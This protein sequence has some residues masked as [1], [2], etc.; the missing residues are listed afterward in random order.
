[1]NNLSKTALE[2]GVIVHDFHF[3]FDA[4]AGCVFALDLKS[5]KFVNFNFKFLVFAGG[6]FS[7]NYYTNSS[8][9][10][11]TGDCHALALKLGG[12]MEDAE[13][14]QFHPTG[15][16]GTGI[17]ISEAVRAE[18]GILL[19]SKGERFMEKYSPNFLE[20][21]PRDVIARAIFAEGGGKNP[22][23]LSLKNI[24]KEMIAKKLKGTVQTAKFFGGVDVFKEDI[25]VFPTSHYNM[26]G[27]KV[28]ENYRM[29]GNI[30][31]IGECAGG[32][33]HGANRLG[34]NSLLELFT[35]S[36]LVCKEIKQSKRDFASEVSINLDFLNRLPKITFEELLKIKLHLAKLMQEKCGVLRE[37]SKMQ[38]ALAEVSSMLSE[39]EKASPHINSLVFSNSFVLY[40]EVKNLLILSIEVLKSAIKR[41]ESRGSHTRI[42]YP[43][44]NPNLDRY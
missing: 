5:G 26:G 31:A 4:S 32:R 25:P 39:I 36:T 23:Y 43:D 28:D 8:S 15:L 30:F 37:E 29:Q 42:D 11:L 20:L 7:Q 16:F 12:E 21:A 35:S 24:E 40:F 13:F 18:G 38:E 34:C 6:G 2:M 9:N 44:L 14:V 3:I 10:A 41:R 17:L 19:N 27:I 1:M 33:I 22:A